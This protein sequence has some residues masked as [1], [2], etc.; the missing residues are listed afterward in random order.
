MILTHVLSRVKR[1]IKSKDISKTEFLHNSPWKVA[2][3]QSTRPKRHSRDRDATHCHILSDIT[4]C[5]L[6]CLVVSLIL[7]YFTVFPFQSDGK[8]TTP[9]A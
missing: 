6:I 9:K 3:R 2:K 8:D 5:P 7:V 1:A 4:D